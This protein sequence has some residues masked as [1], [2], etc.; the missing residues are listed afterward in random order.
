MEAEEDQSNLLENLVEFQNKSKPK[1]KEGKDKKEIFMKV[2]MLFM[3]VENYSSFK[4]RIFPIKATQDEDTT[5]KILTL[6]KCFK[7]YQ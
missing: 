5:L 6:N 2:R 7:D 1:N 4:R 3:K